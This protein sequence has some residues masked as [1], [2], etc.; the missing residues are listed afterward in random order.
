VAEGIEDAETGAA[1]A[2]LEC[3]VPQGFAIARP[4][5]V[6]DF[7]RWLIT[8]RPSLLEQSRA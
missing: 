8:P 2:R 4:M 1:L 7:L 6:E 5:P 3:D